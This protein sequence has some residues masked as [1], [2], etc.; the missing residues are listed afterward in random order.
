ME[1]VLTEAISAVL[2]VGVF[3]LI[4]FIFFLFRKDKS[5]SFTRYIG[6][7]LPPS[8]ASLYAAVTALLFLIPA[9]TVI[10]VDDGVREIVFNPPSVTGKLRMMELGASAIITL[11]LIALLKTS[12]SEEIFFRGFIAKRFIKGFGF[13]VGN[14]LQAL[15][16]GAIHLLLFW[17]LMN[18]SLFALTFI[19]VSSTLAGWV[20]GLIKEK[21]GQGSIIP[22]WIAHG[23]GNTVSY[24]VIAFV[25]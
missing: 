17:K 6:F 16:F 23:L 3:T 9:I 20:I 10:Y 7:Y 4:P 13:G 2:Q 19:F 24:F 12:L 5:V 25:L 14:F 11:L 8:K 18:A 21:Y 1:N 15:L 22:G